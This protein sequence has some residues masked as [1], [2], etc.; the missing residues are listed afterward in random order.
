MYVKSSVLV[1]FTFSIL[2]SIF[3]PCRPYKSSHLKHPCCQN[4]ICGIQLIH[5]DHQC[6]ILNQAH[7]LQAGAGRI[8]LNTAV[9]KFWFTRRS[10]WPF[11]LLPMHQTS[12]PLIC[13]QVFNMSFHIY[14]L[15]TLQELTCTAS[16]SL[17]RN[18]WQWN[19]T[20]SSRIRHTELS[21]QM[22]RAREGIYS[23]FIINITLYITCLH[24]YSGPMYDK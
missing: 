18:M 24:L 7:T 4:K 14:T 2:P 9:L 5:H 20:S 13:F 21:S 15:P 23:M 12:P 1:S 22:P 16:A 8:A 6:I 10:W 19:G 17:K 3:T 11:S